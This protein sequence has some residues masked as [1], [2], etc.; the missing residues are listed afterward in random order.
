[1]K[2]LRATG[3]LCP[4]LC[5]IAATALSV[6][7]L[8]HYQRLLSEQRTNYTYECSMRLSDLWM[9]ARNATSVAGYNYPTNIEFFS[10]GFRLTP[11]KESVRLHPLLCPGSE[12]TVKQVGKDITHADYVYVN[13]GTSF[14][15]PTNVPGAYPLFF[16]RA[17]SNHAGKG[18]YVI[19]VDGSVVW[20]PG[21]TWIRS[22]AKA[23]PEYRI[24]LPN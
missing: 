24:Q 17:L 13:W 16:D 7:F 6:A 1:M 19:R 2:H 23:H 15:A 21:A 18:V 14:G 5:A 20:D 3:W 4:L 11:S 9:L 22:F 8:A 12:T 10:R